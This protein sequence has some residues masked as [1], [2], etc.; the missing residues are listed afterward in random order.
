MEEVPYTRWLDDE[1]Q[2]AWRRC[3]AGTAHILTQLGLALRRFDLDLNE[4]E[5]LVRLSE[6]DPHALRMSELAKNTSQSRSRLT[7]T[8]SRMEK[9]GLVVRRRASDDRRGIIAELTTDGM[10]LLRTAAP[11]HVESVREVFIDRVDPDDLQAIGRAMAAVLE[12]RSTDDDSPAPAEDDPDRQAAV[13][14]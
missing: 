12:G 9:R 8:I 10:D 13:T 3:L 1:Q 5:I 11:T 4:Y 7:H 2:M 6:S 14:G